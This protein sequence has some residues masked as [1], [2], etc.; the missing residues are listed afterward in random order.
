MDSA[1][2]AHEARRRAVFLSAHRKP[3]AGGSGH[4]GEVPEASSPHFPVSCVFQAVA[5]DSLLSL[6]AWLGEL[7]F[8]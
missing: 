7:R 5:R 1:R 2:V 3:D 8:K 4:A 6:V